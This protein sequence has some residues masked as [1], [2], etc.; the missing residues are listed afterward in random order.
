M[1]LSKAKFYRETDQLTS[2]YAQSLTHPARLE[3]LRSL[4]QQDLMSVN[5]M[6]FGHPISLPA[7]SQHLE[8][9]RK[10][11][12]IQYQPQFPFLLYSLNQ[13]DYEKARHCLIQFLNEI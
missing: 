2:F 8:I 9:L 1:L 13:V 4:R 11:N 7:V 6:A 5:E 10:K 3:I 12:L